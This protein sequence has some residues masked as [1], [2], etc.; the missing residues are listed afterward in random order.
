MNQIEVLYPGLITLMLLPVALCL[1]RQRFLRLSAQHSLAHRFSRSDFQKP[2][3][4]LYFPRLLDWAMILLIVVA[5]IQPVL[6]VGH[7]RTVVQS[8]DL[9]LCLDLS[10]SMQQKIGEDDFSDSLPSPAPRLTRLEAVKQVALELID[11]R[12]QDRIGLVVFSANGYVVNPL[13]ADHHILSEYL[14]MVDGNTLIGEGLTSVGEG[15]NASIE[16]L[17][18]FESNGKKQGKAII[19]FTDAEQNYGLKPDLPLERARVNKTKLYF[20]GVGNPIEAI[21]GQLI[22]V[23]RATGGDSFNAMNTQELRKAFRQIDYLERNPVE[24]TEYFRNQGLYP[25]FLNITLVLTILSTGLR[26]FP[27]FYTLG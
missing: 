17:S 6:S 1:L 20:I 23:I 15:L 26:A 7:R 16:L 13:T 27:I 4:W 3:T 11:S 9:V 21:L 25:L 8:L 14:K 10:A 2:P 12:P 24:V 18:F 5:L 22:S 19:M